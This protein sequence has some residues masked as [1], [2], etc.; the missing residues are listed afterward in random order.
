MTEDEFEKN[1]K[2]NFCMPREK[3]NPFLDCSIRCFQANQP[4]NSENDERR[5]ALN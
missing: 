3:Q 5:A 4:V 2:L 1:V